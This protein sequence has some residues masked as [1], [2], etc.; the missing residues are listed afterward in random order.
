MLL[1]AG[2]P[3]ATLSGPGRAVER[4]KLLLDRKAQALD[5]IARS[6]PGGGGGPARRAAVEPVAAPNYNF[7]GFAVASAPAKPAGALG[8]LGSYGDSD[9]EDPAAE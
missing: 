1:V 8:L 2:A 6:K 5:F 9:E 4:A 7:S 3:F